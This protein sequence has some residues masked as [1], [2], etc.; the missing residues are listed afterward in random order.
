MVG[1]VHAG[2]VGAAAVEVDL[3]DLV[4]VRRVGTPEVF[5]PADGFQAAEAAPTWMPIIGLAWDRVR[6]GEGL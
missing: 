5:V 1:I 3:G 6:K 4:E 2:A